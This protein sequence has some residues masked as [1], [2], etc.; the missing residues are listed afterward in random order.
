MNIETSIHSRAARRG[1]SPPAKNALKAPIEETDYKPWLHNAQ[2]AGIGKKKKN[3]PLSRQ[4][5]LRQQRGFE[6]ADVNFDKLEKKVADS[7][8]R[9]REIKARSIEWEELNGKLAERMNGESKKK[10][11]EETDHSDVVAEPMDE[12]E[13][14]ALQ[15]QASLPNGD[16]SGATKVAAEQSQSIIEP[17]QDVDEIT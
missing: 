15:Q 1:D 16:T 10:T 2:N 13:A 9:G 8:N 4:Q 11:S 14:L 12:V 6:K 3:K 7:K 17:V 5:R